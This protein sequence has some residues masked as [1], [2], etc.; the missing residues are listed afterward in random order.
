MK[1]ITTLYKKDVN[2]LSRVI[3]EVNPENE[4]V[5]GSDV[6]ATQ[7]FD[8]S[9]CMIKDCILYKRYDAKKGREKPEYGI[10]CQE[11]D[12]ITGHQPYWVLCY[13]R[14]PEDKYFCEAFEAM[15]DEDKKLPACFDSLDGTYELCGEKVE[16]NPEH[17]KGHK[18][19]KHG[20]VV[21]DISDYS[22][23][24]LKAYLSNP[25]NDIEGIVFHHTD[26]RMCKIR[27]SDFGIKRQHGM[28]ENSTIK[29]KL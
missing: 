26:G 14:K 21:L 17:I 28:E 12:P 29:V 2:N 9:A 6:I 4:W 7:K 20:S 15:V 1:K 23:E 27:K 19:L 13:K 3:K 8:G 22:F 16:G 11:E 25:L 24:G 10:P 18:L 5:F